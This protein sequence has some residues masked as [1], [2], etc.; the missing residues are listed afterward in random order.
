MEGMT[1]REAALERL[2]IDEGFRE[3]A[4]QDTLGN[5][6]V[7]YGTTTR[8]DGSPVQEGD[9]ITRVVAEERLRMGLAAAVGELDGAWPWWRTMGRDAQLGLAMMAYQLGV[10]RLMRFERMRQALWRGDYEVAAL[11]CLRGSDRESLSRWYQQTPR[12]AL[13]VAA[14]FLASHWQ[15]V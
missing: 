6:T 15:D 13:R 2:R 5:W 7:G 3:Q 1:L 14:R 4:Y 11:E 8:I 10:P 12:R 9:R